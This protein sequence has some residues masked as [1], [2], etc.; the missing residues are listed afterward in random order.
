VAPPSSPATFVGKIS[1]KP[2]LFIPNLNDFLCSFR[3]WTLNFKKAYQSTGTEVKQRRLFL[4]LFLGLSSVFLSLFCSYS[5][6]SF[7]LLLVRIF[8]FRLW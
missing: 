6:F 5:S 4:S 2:K 8:G 7:V 3:I 1:S